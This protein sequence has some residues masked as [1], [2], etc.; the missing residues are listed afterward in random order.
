MNCR[1]NGRGSGRFSALGCELPQAFGHRG[2]HL[3]RLSPDELPH[4]RE[5]SESSL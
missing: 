2:V 1:A 4:Y 5:I 3:G